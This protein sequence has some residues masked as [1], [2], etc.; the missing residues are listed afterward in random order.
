MDL[1]LQYEKLYRYCYFRLRD[2]QAAEDVTQEAFLR[3]LEHGQ[4]FGAGHALPYLYTVAK[5][6]CADF[7]RRQSLHPVV[8]L[9]EDMRE[10]ETQNRENDLLTSLMIRD[11]LAA[12][13]ETDRDLLF[14][15]YANELSIQAICRITGLSRFAVYRRIRRLLQTLAPPVMNHFTFLLT[16]IGYIRKWVWVL[17]A[18]VF[19][20]ILF[21]AELLPQDALWVV[22]ALLPF[23]ALTLVTENA[24]SSVCKMA[25]LEMASRFSL[26]NVA[27]ARLEILGLFHGLLF[28][29]LLLLGILSRPT[30]FLQFGLVLLIP[31]LAT[32]ALGLWITRRIRGRENFYACFGAA[33]LMAGAQVSFHQASYLFARIQNPVRQLAAVLPLLYLTARELKKTLHETEDLTCNLS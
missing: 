8:G 12:L 29:A 18:A 28:A 10:T 5:N 11:A 33:V 24:R 6:L 30:A 27:L 26:K 21:C 14:L 15:R 20:M 19:S 2:P 17:S 32:C 31:Y 16:Q 1:D 23:V 4:S 9:E 25:E 22:S 3:F 7:A 13:D